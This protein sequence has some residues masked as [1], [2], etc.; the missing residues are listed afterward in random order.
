MYHF[1]VKGADIKKIIQKTE[2]PTLDIIP[3]THDLV[4]LDKFL[5]TEVGREEIFKD[6]L[7]PHLQ[8]YD[9][10]IFDNGPSWNHLIENAIFAS[11]TI[12]CPLGCNL[13][14][15]NAS[16][17]NFDTIKEFQRKKKLFN[18]II[19]AYATL[20]ERSGISQQI[21]S[22][23][24]SGHKDSLLPDTPI[25]SS[26]KWQEALMAGISI[27]EYVPEGEMVENYYN[28]I[29]HMWTRATR[30]EVINVRNSRKRNTKTSPQVETQNG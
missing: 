5:G 21:Y 19:I 16:K 18:Q 9:V 2:I 4:V 26:V 8:E 1:F 23:Y 3:E 28:L 20:V 29:T 14:A 6:K 24:I 22:E 10:I 17:T 13:L 12:I 30:G 15:Y 11:D 27:L 25:K 7:L